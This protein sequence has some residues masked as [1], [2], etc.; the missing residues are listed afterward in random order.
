MSLTCLPLPYELTLAAAGFRTIQREVLVQVDS[1]ARVELHLQLATVEE[2]VEV[3]GSNVVMLSSTSGLGTVIDRKRIESL[4]LNR[5]DFLQLAL[6]A[7]GVG[8]PV[9]NSELSSRGG[10][11]IHVN[12]GREE[13]N[14]FLLDGIDNNDP[15]VKRYVVQ[16]SVDSVQ[17]FK[18]ATNSYGAEYGRDSGGQ[19]NV[20]TRRGTN[21]FEG[22][23]YEYMRHKSLDAANYFEENGKQPF[24]RNQ[25]GGGVGGPL[26]SEHTFF[27]GALDLLRQRQGL[28]RLG[29]VP[30]AAVR[31]GDLSGLGVTV[32]DPFTGQPF[33]GNVIPASR[34]SPLARQ[35]V[36]MFPTPNRQG[37]PNYLGQPEGRDGSTQGMLRLDHRFSNADEL[38]VRYSDGASDLLEPYTEGTDSTAGYGSVVNDRTQNMLV[39][40]NHVFSGNVVNALRFG[41]NRF[42]RDVLTE[43][44]ATNVGALWGVDWLDVPASSNGFPILNVAGYSKVGDAFTLPILRDATT[45]Q[46]VDDLTV[47]AGTHL[48]KVG[49]EVRDINLDSR[50]DLFTRGQL[51]FTGAFTGSGIGDLLIGLPTFDLHAQADNPIQLR[52]EAYSLYVQDDW[53]VRPNLT[54]NVGARYE[55]VSPPVDAVDGMSTLNASTGTLVNV[56]TNGVSRSGIR[57]DRNNLAPRFGFSWA[58]VAG[59]IVRGGYGIF[60]DSSMLTVNSAQYF[61][62][63][64]FN[65]SVFTPGPR[66]LLSIQ[67]PFPRNGGFAPPATLS[68]LS[69]DLVNGRL[70]HWNVAVQREV[71]V[72]GSVSLAYGGSKGSNLVRPRDLNQPAPGPGDV[73]GRRPNP[74]Y[75]NIFFVESA[76][77]SRYDSFQA[78]VDRR[79]LRGSSLLTV[80]TPQPIE[81]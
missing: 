13:A 43:N 5:R 3:S 45:Y 54:L 24:R 8:G 58:P 31:T 40:H 12:G 65:L 81:R 78:T 77:R 61:N 66:G 29:V 19:I 79:M 11:A 17:E 55:Y 14:N 16:P 53:R 50:V 73:Q 74:A 42:K 28:S 52:T 36:N 70:Q 47:T 67:D 34:I 39:H 72:L 33:P 21:R 22:F 64:Y 23:G 32:K 60:Y 18:V 30:S 62:P 1:S 9:E 37:S 57:P 10:V 35:M 59:T 7:P 6:L 48:L 69:P 63:P 51:S 25:F 75:S 56:G 38:T 41:A 4:P 26:L 20:V 80:Y 71:P 46:V 76:G 2:R 15:Y 27:F 49:G 44:S 68:V